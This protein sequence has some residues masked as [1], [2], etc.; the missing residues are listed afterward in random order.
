MAYRRLTDSGNV[1]KISMQDSNG[2]TWSFTKGDPIRSV[3]GVG[4]IHFT[5]NG[6]A[7]PGEI[8]VNDGGTKLSGGL[9]SIMPSGRAVSRS[10]W[11]RI[12]SMRLPV[13]AIRSPSGATATQQSTAR[14]LYHPGYRHGHNVGMSQWGAYSMAKFYSMT[15]LQILTFYYTELQSDENKRFP[16]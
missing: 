9:S 5:I 4:S 10:F 16:L 14:R 12:M 7:S 13:P 8:Y 6:S 2:V 1:Y 11:G 3:L 15:Y